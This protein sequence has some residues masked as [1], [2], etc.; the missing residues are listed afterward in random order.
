[1]CLPH[2]TYSTVLYFSRNT[3]IFI[4]LLICFVVVFISMYFSTLF[5]AQNNNLFLLFTTYKFSL[6][7]FE[8]SYDR[9]LI[10]L[11]TLAS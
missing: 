1:M 4:R 6:G 11:K 5:I 3:V 10:Y 9:L 2:I 7:V 8:D